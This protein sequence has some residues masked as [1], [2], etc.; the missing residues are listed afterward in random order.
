MA[1]PKIDLPIFEVIVPHSGESVKMRP[2]TVKEEKVLLVAQE[3]EDASA[4]LIAMKQV[5]GNC[6]IDVDVDNLPL[7]ELEFL[8]LQLRAR[9]VDNLITF[10]VSDPDTNEA[11]TLELKVDEIDITIPEGHAMSKEVKLNDNYNLFLKYPSI[12]AFGVITTM[13]PEDPLINY[14]IMRECLDKVA[15]EDEIDNFSD[16]TSEEIDAFMEDL[17]GA[18]LQ[19]IVKFFETMPKLRH[20][21]KYTNSEGKEQTFVVEG[22]RSFFI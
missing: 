2:F 3:A 21:I 17:P 12:D 1:L 20:E 7:F 13:D 16:Y 5:L 4:E 9:S 15:S 22:T 19:K 6:L 10:N 18:V 14:Y 8:L 11:V